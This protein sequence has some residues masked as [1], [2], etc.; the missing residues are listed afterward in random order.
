MPGLEKYLEK[1]KAFLGGKCC[2][3]Q[4]PLLSEGS[5]LEFVGLHLGRKI[6]KWREAST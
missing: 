4:E 6:T 2:A 5:E 1:I 3:M